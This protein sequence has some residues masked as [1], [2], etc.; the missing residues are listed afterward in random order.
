MRLQPID[1]ACANCASQLAFPSLQ[2]ACTCL[3]AVTG[4]A[5][6]NADGL[7]VGELPS[8]GMSAD[9]ATAPRPPRNVRRVRRAAASLDDADLVDGIG[10]L[11]SAHRQLAS[12][13][14]P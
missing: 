4:P 5:D 13:R 12:G 2:L 11:H 3:A 6:V 14:A 7:S 1:R 10:H 9:P 8:R